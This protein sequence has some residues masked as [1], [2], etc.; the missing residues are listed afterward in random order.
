L[1]VLNLFIAFF[2]LFAEE[3]QEAAGNEIE[4][5]AHACIHHTM[6]CMLAASQGPQ[7]SGLE[8]EGFNLNSVKGL[9]L[10]INRSCFNFQSIH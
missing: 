4:G 5:C 9:L 10:G 3:I 2:A 1:L 6:V 8:L 7:T